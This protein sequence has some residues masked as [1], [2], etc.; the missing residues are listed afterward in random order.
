MAGLLKELDG[1]IDIELTGFDADG[2]EELLQEVSPVLPDTGE[3]FDSKKA[4]GSLEDLAPTPQEMERLKGKKLLLE[5]S[6]GKDSSAAALW[7]KHFFPEAEIEL[8]FIEMGADFIGFER[9]LHKFADYLGVKLVTL[10]S[11]ENMIEHMLAK[12]EWPAFGFPYCH[13]ILHATG[14]AYWKSHK[15]EDVVVLRGGRKGEKS[16]SGKVNKTRWLEIDRLKGFAF[17]Q[18]FYFADKEDAHKLLAGCGA[19]IWE[20]YSRGLCRTA[21]R[22]CPGQRPRAYASLRDN[23]PDVW[24]E[25][26]WMESKLGPG[27]WQRSFKP[28]GAHPSFTQVADH[29]LKN[30]ADDAQDEDELGVEDLDAEAGKSNA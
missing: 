4:V 18:P 15:P 28:K 23:Y 22:I 6:G 25:L 14:D 3:K 2:L 30:I 16:A 11:P 12:G 8:V 21:C 9:H 1:Q 19:P 24:E 5:F 17:F 10:R 13:D 26:L 20:G 27:A 7:T 29:G